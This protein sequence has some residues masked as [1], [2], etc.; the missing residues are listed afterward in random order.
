[1]AK[2]INMEQ[3]QLENRAAGFKGKNIGTNQ[4]KTQGKFETQNLG[5]PPKQKVSNKSSKVKTFLKHQ[6]QTF[7][8]MGMATTYITVKCQPWYTKDG[9]LMLERQII[10]PKFMWLNQILREFEGVKEFYYSTPEDHEGDSTFSS[11][12]R[13]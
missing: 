8:N 12:V 4:G 3:W 2:A 5:I 6:L 1:M 13:V 10:V 11:L 9:R 7:K